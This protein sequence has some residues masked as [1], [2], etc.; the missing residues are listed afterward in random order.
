MAE[1]APVRCNEAATAPSSLLRCRDEQRP[2]TLSYERRGRAARADSRFVRALVRDR[3]LLSRRPAVGRRKP[4][5]DA[6]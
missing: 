4:S 3:G 1:L 5:L 2:F 6:R